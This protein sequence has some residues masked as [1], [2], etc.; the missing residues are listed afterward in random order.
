M[1][2]IYVSDPIDPD[3]LTDLQLRA[4]VHLGYG[5]TAVSYL[6]IA[7]QV[8]AVLLRGETFGRDKIEASPRLRIIARHGVGTDNVDIEAATEHSIWVTTTPGSNSRAVAEHVFALALAL[9][10]H[11]VFGARATQ[12]GQWA[13]AK[14]HMQGFELSGRTLGLIGFGSVARIVHQIGDALG[15]QTLVCDP[16]L[17][18][19][20]IEEAGA[21]PASLDRLISASDVLSVHVP[22][23]Q[24]TAG[25]LGA[26][27]LDSMKPHAILINTSRG[28]VIDESALAEALEQKK[29]GG[30]ALDV[31]E[32]ESIDMR[33]PIGHSPIA[34]RDLSNLLVT[35]HV[36]GQTDEAF[37]AAGRGAYRSIEQALRGETPDFPANRPAAAAAR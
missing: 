20:Q 10:R 33:H 21:H 7:A 6:D 24:E 27:Q 9:T 28:G 5:E 13:E 18:P 3:V 16:F 11:V 4:D 25:L 8:E 34:A 17:R 14:P 23:T 2:V 15:M 37:T 1:P 36:A 26:E 32:G 12:S 30:A 31:L 29:L 19:A 22:L 35:P